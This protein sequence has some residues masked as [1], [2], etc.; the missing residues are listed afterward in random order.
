MCQVI[1]SSDSPMV[2][3]LDPDAYPNQFRDP[4]YTQHSS[5]T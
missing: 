5:I 2:L 4:G 1:P 3:R